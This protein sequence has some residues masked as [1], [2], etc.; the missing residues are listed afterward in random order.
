[1]WLIVSVL[2]ADAGIGFVSCTNAARTGFVSD[3]STCTMSGVKID[4]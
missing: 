3:V 1:M 4:A 2:R